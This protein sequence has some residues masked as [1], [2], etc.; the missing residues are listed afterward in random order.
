MTDLRSRP[1]EPFGPRQPGIWGGM[2]RFSQ[3]SLT[4]ITVICIWPGIMMA[5]TAV[6]DCFLLLRGGSRPLVSTMLIHGMWLTWAALLVLTAVRLAYGKFSWWAFAPVTV[7]CAALALRVIPGAADPV[8]LCIWQMMLGVAGAQV[9]LHGLW[10][11]SARLLRRKSRK[12]AWLMRWLRV[13]LG[14]TIG[15]SAVLLMLLGS[16]ILWLTCG[17]LLENARD[18]AACAAVLLQALTLLCVMILSGC[19]AEGR[20]GWRIFLLAEALATAGSVVLGTNWSDPGP[21]LPMAVM[22]LL[23]AA[24]LAGLHAILSR[25]EK[26]KKDA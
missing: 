7:A 3:W 10:S 1:R 9:L 5:F 15:V 8:G 20:W 6:M 25:L 4:I 16:V 24:A 12:R 14:L 21:E 17:D 18:A 23:F 13:L 19:R 22:P 2:L 26:E 11:L